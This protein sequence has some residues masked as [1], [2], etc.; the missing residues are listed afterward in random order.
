M[1]SIPDDVKNLLEELEQFL[2]EALASEKSLGKKCKERREALLKTLNELK[3]RYRDV[4][5]KECDQE[6]NG[7]SSDVS[8]TSQT[9]LTSEPSEAAQEDAAGHEVY[10]QLPAIA[11]SDLPNV[12]KAGF[13]DKK[14]KDHSFFVGEWQ[15]RWCVLS[16]NALYYYGDRK[17]KQQKGAVPLAGYSLRPAEATRKD[18]KSCCSFELSAPDKR[19]FQFSTSTADDARS[20]MSYIRQVIRDLRSSVIEEEEDEDEDGGDLYDDIDP[21]E[22]VKATPPATAVHK[23]VAVDPIDEDIYELLPEDDDEEPVVVT[24]TDAAKSAQAPPPVA[25]KPELNS[26]AEA[27]DA[28]QQYDSFYQ[29]LWD[30]SADCVDELSFKR[31]DLVHVLS[32]EY[33]AFRW[34]VG[35]ANGSVGLVPKDYLMAAY[36][37]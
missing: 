24:R 18:R 6:S 13:L 27:W 7:Q 23:E 10:A 3:S 33:D 20:W 14:R 19:S 37:T 4:F 21:I 30:C 2:S 32:K 34:W 35:E 26:A 25:S 9:D 22:Q 17:D 8:S 29:G 5:A 28:T 1:S 15:R 36:D 11:A 16:S 12:I 31:G